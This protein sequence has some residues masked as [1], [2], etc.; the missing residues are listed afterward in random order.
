[1]VTYLGTLLSKQKKQDFR[2]KDDEVSLTTLNTPTCLSVITFLQKLHQVA[3]SS[4]D[5]SNLDHFLEEVG[6]GF[7][8]ILL[9]HLKKFQ[10][11]QAGAIML[12]K[13]VKTNIIISL[14]D[15]TF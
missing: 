12:S 9:D 14:A 8:G 4:L 15:V 6:S 13:W 5:G 10:V 7:Q 1:M 3:L 11:N 2:P